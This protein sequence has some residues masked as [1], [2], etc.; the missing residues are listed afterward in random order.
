MPDMNNPSYWEDP[1]DEPE[2]YHCGEYLKDNKCPHCGGGED[3]E[4]P[5][6]DSYFIDR[7]CDYWNKTT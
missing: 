5:E 3:P 2:C 7:D 4:P 1:P 6:T